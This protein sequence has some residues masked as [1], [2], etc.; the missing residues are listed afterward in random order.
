MGEY[1]DVQRVNFEIKTDK[2]KAALNAIKS[3]ED[4]K[5]FV[6]PFYEDAKNLEYALLSWRWESETNS[7][8]D[9]IDITFIGEKLSDEHILFAALA[10]FVTPGSYI[11]YK[12]GDGSLYRWAFNGKTLL[13]QVPEIIWPDINY[14]KGK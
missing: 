1:L 14:R 5:G 12:L 10:P 2:K 13:E 9:I 3:I 7:A 6:S 11:E 4:P 8:G